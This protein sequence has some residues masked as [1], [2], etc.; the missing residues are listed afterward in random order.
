MICE[1]GYKLKLTTGEVKT[2]DTDLELDAY[3][4][5]QIRLHPNAVSIE[6]FV[7]RAVDFQKNTVDILDEISSKVS[8]VLKPVKKSNGKNYDSEIASEDPEDEEILYYTID[9]SIGVTRFLQTFQQP[10]SGD[11][12]AVKFDKKS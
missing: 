1:S 9:N 5:E 8:S 3:I 4:D 2:F 11:P 6:D 7:T 12:F 10:S